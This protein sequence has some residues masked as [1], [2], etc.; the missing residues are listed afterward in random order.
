MDKR[1]M[2]MVHVLGEMYSIKEIDPAD[3]PKLNGRRDGYTDTSIK[4]C[5]IDNM[6]NAQTDDKANLEE[7]KKGVIRHELIHAFLYESGLDACSWAMNEEM[8]DWIALQFPKMMKA[9]KEA[10]CL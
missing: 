5:V 4:E 6:S 10:G 3:D 7:Y 8:I 2:T 9:F 1:L